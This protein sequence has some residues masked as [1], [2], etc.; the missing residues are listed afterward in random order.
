M[1][2]STCKVSKLAKRVRVRKS[3]NSWR[4]EN[5]D[6]SNMVSELRNYFSARNQ[7]ALQDADSLWI[8][9]AGGHLKDVRRPLGRV[10]RFKGRLVK[11]IFQSVF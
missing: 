9:N 1:T 4:Q 8:A 11:R 7:L 10:V 6:I 3:K 5:D 2:F